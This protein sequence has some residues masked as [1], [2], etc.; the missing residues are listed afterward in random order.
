M[1]DQ[2]EWSQI[3]N[4][5]K[6][7]SFSEHRQDGSYGDAPNPNLHGCNQ[8]NGNDEI[9]PSKGR[10]NALGDIDESNGNGDVADTDKSRPETFNNKESILGEKDRTKTFSRNSIESIHTR[11]WWDSFPSVSPICTGDDGISD[12][13]DSIT[14][15]KWRNE[16]IKAGGNA[17]VPQVVLQIFKTIEQYEN[18][19]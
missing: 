9:N 11:K 13:L 14:F 19:H 1:R 15:P 2:R 7:Q 8:R 4:Q 17:I 16:S 6:G 10:L 3:D 5:R 18:L 12:R